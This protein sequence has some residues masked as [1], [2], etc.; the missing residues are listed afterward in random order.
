MR[1]D[2]FCYHLNPNCV[3]CRRLDGLLQS[4]VQLEI[5]QLKCDLREKTASLYQKITD[6]PDIPKNMVIMI[7]PQQ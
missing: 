4:Q 2:D 6:T 7:N 1:N 3:S 5:S